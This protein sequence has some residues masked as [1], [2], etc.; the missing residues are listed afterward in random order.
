MTA[1][2]VAHGALVDVMADMRQSPWDTALPPG[3]I[4][5]GHADGVR[6]ALLIDARSPWRFPSA[7]AVKLVGNQPLIPTHEGMGGGERGGVFALLTAQGM[8]Q[9]RESAA[10]GSGEASSL[11]WQLGF[12][13]LIVCFEGGDDV[14]LVSRDPTGNHGEENLQKHG[15]SWGCAYRRMHSIEYA[16]NPRDFNGVASANFFNTTASLWLFFHII[17]GE[18][19]R[20]DVHAWFAQ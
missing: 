9:G 15:D 11:W 14:L 8:S 2:H 3:G 1:Y 5:S 10:L 7:A 12:E 4:R 16:A 17:Q 20:K 13:H 19:Q 6:L 18:I